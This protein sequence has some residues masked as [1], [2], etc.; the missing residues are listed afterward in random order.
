MPFFSYHTAIRSFLFSAG[1]FGIFGFISIGIYFFILSLFSDFIDSTW[2]LTSLAYIVSMIFNYLSQSMFT[3]QVRGRDRRTLV[4]Y[5]F[6]HVG[7]MTFNS[8]A[9]LLLVDV[10]AFNLWPA[11]ICVTFC[12]AASS[13]LLSKYWVF[14]EA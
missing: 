3:F 11:Q 1:K 4:R 9:M 7:C 10:L 12:V 8:A 13:F 6:L 2:L 14:V 5:F